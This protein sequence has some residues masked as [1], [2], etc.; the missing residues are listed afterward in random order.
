M[1]SQPN[2]CRQASAS[3]PA[4]L[5]MLLSAALLAASCTTGDVMALQPAVDVGQRTAAVASPALAPEPVVAQ[6]QL[7]G[8]QTLVPSN[9]MMVAYPRV[10]QPLSTPPVMPAGEAECRR[11]LRRLGVTW[12]DLAPIDDG[13]SCNIANPV[14][15]S[16]IGSA[17]I[18]PAATVTCQMALTFARWTKEELVPSARLRYFSGVKRIN[19]GSSYSCRRISGSR[20][21]SEHSTGNAIDIMNIELNNDKDI[22]VKKPGFF[23][24]RQRGLLN[25]VRADACKYFTTV[26]GPGYNY[27]H[28]NHFHFDIMQRRNGSVACR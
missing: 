15:M 18:K 22:D 2:L 25:N 20:T 17:E 24:F 8:M 16:A 10:E 27:D 28:R 26:L 9:P 5:G 1:P 13:P 3:R 4:L 19:Q 12:R 23:S 21:M 11:Q 7:T 14:S 6:Q